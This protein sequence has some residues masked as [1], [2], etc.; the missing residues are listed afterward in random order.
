[1][2]DGVR[3][4]LQAHL[5]WCLGCF[6]DGNAALDEALQVM[7][8]GQDTC[9]AAALLCPLQ[10]GAQGCCNTT[11]VLP[12]MHT[13]TPFILQQM[14]AE[15]KHCRFRRRTSTG[16]SQAHH[17]HLPGMQTDVAWLRSRD[18]TAWLL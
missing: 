10:A 5:A 8:D 4:S 17:M 16:P 18:G 15:R 11:H 14:Q 3:G 12:V 9:G 7:L 6:V 2:A 1:M 13:A